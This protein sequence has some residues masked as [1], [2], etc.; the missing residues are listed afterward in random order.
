MSLSKKEFLVILLPQF[1][2]SGGVSALL[3]L[4]RSPSDK[5][6]RG[7]VWALSVCAQSSD[8]AEAACEMG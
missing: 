3:S 8:V 4:L 2:S 5:V 1:S 6:C 7:A